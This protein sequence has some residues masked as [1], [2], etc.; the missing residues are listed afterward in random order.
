MWGTRR[1]MCDH[2]QDPG[3]GG[4]AGWSGGPAGDEKRAGEVRTQEKTGGGGQAQD[5]AASRRRQKEAALA[6]PLE[7][8]ERATVIHLGLPA[9]SG[10]YS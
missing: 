9:S 8:P 10:P 7:P 4:C 1:R 3:R 5:M 2:T 6:S